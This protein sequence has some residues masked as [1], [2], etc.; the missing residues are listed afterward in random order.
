MERTP[1]PKSGRRGCQCADGTY[2]IE[3]CDG[4]SQGIGGLTGGGSS[5]IVFVDG[6]EDVNNTSSGGELTCS[7]ININGFSVDGNGVITLPTVNIGTIVSTSPSSFATVSQITSRTL[8][9]T[10]TVPAEYENE[11]DDII[12]TTTASQPI[13]QL[14]TDGDGIPDDIDTDDDGDGLLDEDEDGF[15]TD[16]LDADS[17]DDGTDDGQEDQ[18]GDGVLNEDEILVDLACSDITLSGFA[19]AQD[20]TITLPSTDIGTILSTT[21]SSFDANSGNANISRTLT[22]T[23]DVP[24]GYKNADS[25][26][27][28]TVTAD[29][30]YAVPLACGDIT[31]TGFAVAGNGVVTLPTL[32]EGSI[33][34]STPTSFNANTGASAVSRTVTLTITVPSGYSNSGNTIDCDVTADQPVITLFSPQAHIFYNVSGTSSA[35]SWRVWNSNGVSEVISGVFST[36][37][38][39]SSWVTPVFISGDDV[40]FSELTTGGIGNGNFVTTGPTSGSDVIK[41]ATSESG[42]SSGTILTQKIFQAGRNSS[43]GS[44]FNDSTGNLVGVGVYSG[45]TVIDAQT[46]PYNRPQDGWYKNTSNG[47]GNYRVENG[48]IVEKG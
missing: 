18:D 23:I 11:G 45:N 10:I 43:T 31:F 12:C 25:T 24:L 20:G 17:D 36:Y 27:D 41:Y 29:Q 22:V 2:R 32:S 19:V 39:F 14:D 33:A 9:V 37:V 15:G 34:S 44:V 8:T 46:S 13:Y 7:N 6:S 21:P 1:Y 40:S 3:C 4:N 38:Q 35:T 42:L 16:P 26:I 5:T 48:I 30:P 47:N 28:C